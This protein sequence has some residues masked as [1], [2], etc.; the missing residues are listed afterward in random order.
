MKDKKEIIKEFKSKLSILKKHNK[1]YYINDKPEI[2]DSDYD[3]I[4]N[5]IISLKKKY[6][7]LN[8]YLIYF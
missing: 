4:K 8:E 3:D 2:S 5:N 1:L 7:F 6:S